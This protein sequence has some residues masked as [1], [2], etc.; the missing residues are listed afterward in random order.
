MLC[1]VLLVVGYVYLPLGFVVVVV[2]LTVGC[3]VCLGFVVGDCVVL[4]WFCGC[5]VFIDYGLSC[6]MF[7]SLNCLWVGLL[8]VCLV[9]WVWFSVLGGVLLFVCRRLVFWFRFV[10]GWSLGWFV[11]D[12][13][14]LC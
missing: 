11:P 9:G 6:Y 3:C 7:V 12:V 13:V 1:V 10:F 2:R 5:L 4:L 14:W 8:V